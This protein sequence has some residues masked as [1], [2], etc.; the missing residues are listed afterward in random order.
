[1]PIPVARLFLS[2][3]VGSIGAASSVLAGLA[4]SLEFG[5]EGSF[6]LVRVA[7]FPPGDHQEVRRAVPGSAVLGHEALERGPSIDERTIDREVF[8]RKVAGR[9]LDV[10]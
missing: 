3:S 4:V 5:F 6:G 8:V 9:L 2:V 7:E 10:R 1:M